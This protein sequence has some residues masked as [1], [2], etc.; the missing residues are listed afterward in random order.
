MDFLR[1]RHFREKSADQ[2]SLSDYSSGNKA[3]MCIQVIKLINVGDG[4]YF[5]DYHY[6]RVSP[7]RAQ[8]SSKR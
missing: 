4:V 5:P 3:F 7:F 6:S 8:V 2:P 1:H